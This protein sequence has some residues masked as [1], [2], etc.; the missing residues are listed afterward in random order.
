MAEV[1]E[2]ESQEGQNFS[3]LQVF[4]TGSGAP[5]SPLSN[6]VKLLGREADHVLIKHR[7][8]FTLFF[9]HYHRVSACVLSLYFASNEITYISFDTRVN[10]HCDLF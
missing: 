9:Y 5:P 10:L 1:L 7:D 8:N 2:F 6:G 4:Q 3:P